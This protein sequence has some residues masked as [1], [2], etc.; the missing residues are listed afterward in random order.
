MEQKVFLNSALQ[1]ITLPNSI[2]FIGRRAIPQACAIALADS[3][4]TEQFR[5]WLLALRKNKEAIFSS[6]T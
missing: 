1:D 3:E 6:A 4:D 2:E 5:L